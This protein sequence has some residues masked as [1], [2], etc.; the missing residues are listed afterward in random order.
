M[1]IYL[2]LQQGYSI[3]DP[4]GINEFLLINCAQ[5]RDPKPDHQ[6]VLQ[7]AALKLQVNTLSKDNP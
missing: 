6:G 4:I 7:I 3:S 2:R 5:N 1:L